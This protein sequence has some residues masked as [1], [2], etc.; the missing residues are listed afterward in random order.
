MGT[1]AVAT[2]TA[3]PPGTLIH[4]CSQHPEELSSD[5]CNQGSTRREG[6]AAEERRGRDGHRCTGRHPPSRH[7]QVQADILAPATL[8]AQQHLREQ[9]LSAARPLAL[10]LCS[11]SPPPSFNPFHACLVLSC[12]KPVGSDSKETAQVGKTQAIKGIL[13]LTCPHNLRLLLEVKCGQSS[14]ALCPHTDNQNTTKLTVVL[15]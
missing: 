6:A 7:P 5:H 14:V 15:G 2:S 9:L 12:M 1:A 3:K 10:L 11:S 8:P 4:V 13:Q